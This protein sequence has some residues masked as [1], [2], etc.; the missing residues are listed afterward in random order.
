MIGSLNNLNIYLI[1]NQLISHNFNK[2][3]AS[4]LVIIEEVERDFD[5]VFLVGLEL[6]PK[7]TLELVGDD[8]AERVVAGDN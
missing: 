8:V 1:R 6:L 2:K 4:S 3:L 5:C 7:M